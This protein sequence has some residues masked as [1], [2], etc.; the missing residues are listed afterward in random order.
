MIGHRKALSSAKP[1]YRFG[2]LLRAEQA[3]Q[4][5][6][7]AVVYGKVIGYCSTPV[8]SDNI[9]DMDLTE[10]FNAEEKTV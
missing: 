3:R 7:E 5:P 1:V 4:A 2:D 8:V 10:I 9:L 6:A